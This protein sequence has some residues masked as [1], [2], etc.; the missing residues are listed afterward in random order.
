MWGTS[1]GSALRMM[2]SCIRDLLLF[3]LDE[4][5]GDRGGQ[6]EPLLRLKESH[7]CLPGFAGA[8]DEH[9]RLPAVPPAHLPRLSRAGREVNVLPLHSV[10]AL[11]ANGRE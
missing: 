4:L 3:R 10:Q 7:A 1:A 8:H 6:I 2:L 9:D 11:G 5:S